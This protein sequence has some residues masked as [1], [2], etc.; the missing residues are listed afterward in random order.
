MA[1]SCGNTAPIRDSRQTRFARRT[2]MATAAWSSTPRSIDGIAR[3]DADGR[4]VW[5]QKSTRHFWIRCR[6]QVTAR[7]GSSP[8][9]PDA[10]C[11]CGTRTGDNQRA[12][13]DARKLAARSRGQLR[14]T[15]LHL[16]RQ[17]RACVR[18]SRQVAVRSPTRRFHAL[19]CLGGPI[20][21]E[22]GALILCSW[23][24]PIATPAAIGC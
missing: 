3:L 12:R 11:S 19:D 9:S 13:S 17:L 1:R 4:E 16:W 6:E 22:R 10:R 21:G 8:A 5:R 7:H 14:G 20:L 18:S 23:E 15:K 24:R 2:S